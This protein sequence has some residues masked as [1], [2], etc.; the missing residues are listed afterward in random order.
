MNSY[1][2][3]I[4]DE[5][6]KNI[7]D[8]HKHPYDGYVTNYIQDNNQTIYVQDFANDKNGITVD[9]KG[10]V[11]YHTNVGINEDVFSGAKFEPEVSF[12]EVENNEQLDMIGDG[13]DDLIHGTMEEPEFDDLD[14][15]DIEIEENEDMIK[16]SINK[17]LDMFRRFKTVK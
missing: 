1:F 11:K 2:L 12:E 13:E 8:Q 7:L 9:N 3:K 14:E 10:N 15:L 5:D 17:T 4:N 16:E 6:K